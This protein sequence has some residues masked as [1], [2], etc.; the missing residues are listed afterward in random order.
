[1]NINSL[2]VQDRRHR[3]DATNGIFVHIKWKWKHSEG[4]DI[5]IDRGSWGCLVSWGGKAP[6]GEGCK[7]KGKGRER[8]GKGEGG[9]SLGGRD[10]RDDGG[11]LLVKEKRV[12]ERNASGEV[13][14]RKF[15]K[16]KAEGGGSLLRG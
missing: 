2:Q 5:F 1:M 7:G 8:E 4:K 11:I 14:E 3:R 10:Q 15:V 12:E 9:H 16:G 13:R 6:L